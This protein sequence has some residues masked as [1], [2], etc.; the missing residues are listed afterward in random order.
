MR[1]GRNVVANNTR[2]R[3]A[4]EKTSVRPMLAK[5]NT[6]LA[7]ENKKEKGIPEIER[8]SRKTAA[9]ADH[10][11]WR[12]SQMYASTLHKRASHSAHSLKGNCKVVSIESMLSE[13]PDMKHSSQVGCGREL[14]FGR[15]GVNAGLIRWNG[16]YC[17][18]FLRQSG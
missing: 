2:P 10:L 18:G 15:L 3:V 7:N 1:G 13:E 16:K 11:R 4:G 14:L 5:L 17:F 6:S 9:E 8:M 12:F